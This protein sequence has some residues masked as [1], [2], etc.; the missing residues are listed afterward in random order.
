MVT[1]QSIAP[2][3]GEPGT[4]CTKITHCCCDNNTTHSFSTQ[5]ELI[6]VTLLRERTAPNPD[7]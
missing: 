5:R 3:S 4:H 7:T 2:G 6:R 1:N